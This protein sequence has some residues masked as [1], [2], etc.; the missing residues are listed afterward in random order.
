MKNEQR[1]VN[2]TMGRVINRE[3]MHGLFHTIDLQTIYLQTIDL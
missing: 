1:T 3:E 2:Q